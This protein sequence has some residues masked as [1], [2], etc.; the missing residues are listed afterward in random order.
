MLVFELVVY[1]LAT[2]AISV[3]VTKS[4]LFAGLRGFVNRGKWEWPK[5]LVGCNY[6]FSHW[7]AAAI[8]FSSPQATWRS[9]FMVWFGVV[10]LASLWSA[11]IIRVTPFGG[12]AH[13][14]GM[15][16]N[17]RLNNPQAVNTGRGVQP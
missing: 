9:S 15:G 16:P 7:V 14:G 5:D 3:T 8:V 17:G 2:A 6:C 1:S 13:G 10:A 11:A 12:G 4:K